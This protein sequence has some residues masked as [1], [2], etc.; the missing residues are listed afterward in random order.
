MVLPQIIAVGVKNILLFGYGMT[1]GFPTIV[2][3]AIQGGEGRETTQDSRLL[4]NKDEIS[5]FS[6]INLICVPLGCIFS[7][8]I[9]QP[10]GR[11]RAMQL[12]N[13]PIL[14]AWLIFYFSS[15]VYHLYIGLCLA[16]VSGGLLE[17]PVLTYVAEITQPQVRGMLAASGSFFTILGVFT[18]FLLGTFFKWRFIALLSCSIPII[19][20]VLL[21]LIP[22]SPYWLIGKHRLSEAKKSLAWLRGWVA[23]SKVDHEFKELCEIAKKPESRGDEE[24]GNYE[25]C[26]TKYNAYL[27]RTFLWPFA[28]ISYTFFIGHFSGMTTLQT[29]AV[30]IFHTLKAPI[31]KYYATMLLGVAELIGTLLCVILVHFTGKR[32]LVFLSAIGCGLCF[33]ATGTYTHFLHLIPGKTIRNIVANVSEIES[34]SVEDLIAM[35][36]S[37]PEEI[38]NDTSMMDRFD[39][40]PLY[41]IH[42]DNATLDGSSM[43]E[44]N[45]LTDAMRFV[46]NES[47]YVEVNETTATD[48]EKPYPIPDSIIIPLPEPKHNKYLW[49][50]LTLLLGSAVLSHMGIRLIP[51]MLIGEIYPTNVRSCA[52]GL[53]GG[54]GYVFGFLANKLFLEMVGNFTL[55][56]TFWM[57]SFVSLSG[58]VA[59]YFCL[60]ETEGRTLAEIE[61]FFTKSKKSPTISVLVNAPSP[62]KTPP[63]TSIPQRTPDHPVR[64]FQL[65]LSNWESNKIFEQHT[66]LKNHFVLRKIFIMQNPRDCTSIDIL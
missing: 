4:L 48:D 29:Y 46:L 6:S 61:T 42:E 45:L 44:I 60:P 51:W 32:P 16:G 19:S 27:K 20:V 39:Y 57:Y 53:S 47:D 41:E 13:A 65:D 10:I 64:H 21:F 8:S 15:E 3:P 9:T 33:L 36:I 1:L 7:G 55:Y 43:A 25:T 12:V 28:L 54:I 26:L 62:P 23:E 37:M 18:Q 34:Q 31:D 38:F 24:D 52:S 50:P 5:W 63:Q 14:V 35:N 2:I 66:G 22:E 56:G 40:E 49:I 30:Q 11:R 58:A 59:L 17:A